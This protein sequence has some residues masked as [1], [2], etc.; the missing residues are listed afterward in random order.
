MDY[1]HILSDRVA[2]MI[3]SH[4]I[5]HCLFFNIPHLTYDFV[6]NQVASA[7]GI[8]SVILTHSLF[9]NQFY[10]MADVSDYGCFPD[11]DAPPMSVDT[12]GGLD[13]F[14]MNSVGQSAGASGHITPKSIMQL[15]AHLATRRPLK[16][17]DVPWLLRTVRRMHAVHRAFPSWRDPF[18]KFFH[19]DALAYFEHLA[20]YERAEV[21]LNRRFVYFPLQYQPEMTTSAV[22]GV[23]RDQAL[24]IESLSRRLP[25]DVLIY[26][27][28]NPKQGGF[29]RGPMFFHR[30]SRIPNVRIMPSFA[31]TKVL[32][33][34]SECIATI[35]GTVGWEAICMGKPAIV[36]G[37]TWYQGFS[38]VTSWSEDFDFDSCVSGAIDH[39]AI[40]HAAGQLTARA[41][42]GVASRHFA[43]QLKRAQPDF[44]EAANEAKVAA[45]IGGLLRGEVEFTFQK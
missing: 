4:G 23:F 30:L 2:G 14:Y 10:S 1:W 45:T 19:E 17:F 22:G 26:V 21:D 11:G 29:M 42:S 41:H 18:A 15:M 33:A 36:F 39:A 34:N 9:P 25:Q 8:P 31:D 38:G 35:T 37:S 6:V 20:Q 44:D 27:K 5:T 16:A 28:E 40:E 43:R 13:L 24:A 7:M 12:G 3:E 32:T